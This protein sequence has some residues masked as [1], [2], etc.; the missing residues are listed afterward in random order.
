MKILHIATLVTPDGAYGGPIRVA[1][2]QLRELARLG[3]DVELVA[4]T[5]GFGENLPSSIDGVPVRLFAVRQSVP[6]TGY[7]GLTAP[8]LGRYVRQQLEHVDVVH[9]HL[10]RDLITM[11]VARIVARSRTPMVV[12]PHGMIIEP[13]NAT[14]RV[15]DVALT[16]SVLRGSKSVLTLT[17]AESISLHSVAGPTV[18]TE[19][20][21]NGVPSYTGSTHPVEPLDVLFLARLQERKRPQ[22]FVEMAIQLLKEGSDATFS[23]VGP[24]EGEGH[25][26]ETLIRDSNMA[27]RIRWEG[28]LSP[29]K[30]L[31]RIA[32]CGI[33]VL[34]SVGE[35]F[36]MS[37]LEAMSVGRAIVI[38]TSNGLANP[39]M[40]AGA[41]LVVD[42]SLA[43]LVQATRSLLTNSDMRLTLGEKAHAEAERG[44]TMRSV[45]LQLETTYASH[46][47]K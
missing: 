29:E 23:L 14:G 34:P 42:E 36:P 30:T 21:I 17:D 37:V 8:G 6:S 7:A 18:R 3:H 4:G 32:A 5:K 15:F 20:I 44:Y 22:L 2:N 33:Y 41:A 9:V 27:D 38:T 35:V 19:R 25:K 26:I 16:R 40:S 47:V 28:A 1:L 39:L 10:A 11:P 45:A 46:S 13:K 31:E 24:D 12:Q 43:G